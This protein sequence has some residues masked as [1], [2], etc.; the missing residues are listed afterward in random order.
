MELVAWEGGLLGS[1]AMR[2]HVEHEDRVWWISA[3]M[4]GQK[5]AASARA[6]M[7]EVPW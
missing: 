6:V 7:A 4:P 3:V 1:G 5:I 2:L